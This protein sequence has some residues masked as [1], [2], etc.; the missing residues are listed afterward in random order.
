M[1]FP[2]NGFEVGSKLVPFL[3]TVIVCTASVP[4]KNTLAV[5]VLAAS[6]AYTFKVNLLQSISF[7]DCA[8]PI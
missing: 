7:V 1:V 8:N 5:A 2:V 3:E 4:G 6:V